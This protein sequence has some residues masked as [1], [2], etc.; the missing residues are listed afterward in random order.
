MCQRRRV[1][2][3]CPEAIFLLIPSTK[4]VAKKTHKKHL[5]TCESEDFLFAKT[6]QTGSH[7]YLPRY[8]PISVRETLKT[9]THLHKNVEHC[10]FKLMY[11]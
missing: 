9:D 1:H 2:K 3:C 7:V 5:S 4:I 6:E 10:G 8:F 11:N